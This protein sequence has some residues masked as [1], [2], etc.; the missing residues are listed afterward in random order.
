[1]LFGV[2]E[3][4]D[5]PSISKSK[6]PEQK[7]YIFWPVFVDFDNFYQFSTICF[8]IFL[9]FFVKFLQFF[10]DFRPFFIF[11]HFLSINFLQFASSFFFF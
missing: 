7:K 4:V 11:D 2:A 10:L 8:L 3:D 6:N 1:M 9:F 5:T